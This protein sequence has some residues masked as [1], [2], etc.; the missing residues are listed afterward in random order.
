MSAY[1]VN[2]VVEL[3]GLGGLHQLL[4]PS[5]RR[6]VFLV[7][8][9]EHEDSPQLVHAHMLESFEPDIDRLLVLE[10]WREGRHR[11]G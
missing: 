2:Q 5:D 6:K 11:F 4:E 7:V 8:S 10:I 1:Q 3:T 9:S